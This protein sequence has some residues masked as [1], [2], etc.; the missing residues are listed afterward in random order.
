MVTRWLTG[1]DW[2]SQGQDDE[3]AVKPLAATAGLPAVVRPNG[4]TMARIPAAAILGNW[5]LPRRLLADGNRFITASDDG[6]RCA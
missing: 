4:R 3:A 1:R 5:R 2:L 6:Q